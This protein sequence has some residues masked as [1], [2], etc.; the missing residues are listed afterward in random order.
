MFYDGTTTKQGAGPTLAIGSRYVRCLSINGRS[1]VNDFLNSAQTTLDISGVGALTG[2]T[3]AR[4]GAAA[5]SASLFQDGEF[6][7]LALRDTTST[8][9]EHGQLTA[10]YRG[11][12]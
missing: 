6:E 11:G 4:I 2:V 1:P 3:G 5:S 10:Y 12:L 8:A 9:T 7:A